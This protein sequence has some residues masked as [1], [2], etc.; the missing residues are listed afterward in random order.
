MTDA[1]AALQVG[2]LVLVLDDGRLVAKGTPAQL[3]QQV[4]AGDL[5]AT[6]LSS[7]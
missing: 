7:A 2:D 4:Q 5:D 3:H 6:L 1:A